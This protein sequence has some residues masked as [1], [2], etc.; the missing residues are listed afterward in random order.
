MQVLCTL[1]PQPDLHH[2]SSERSMLDMTSPSWQMGHSSLVE[3][4]RTCDWV[5]RLRGGLELVDTGR[6]E[7]LDI[8]DGVDG[9]D[10]V[11]AEIGVARRERLDMSE[12]AILEAGVTADE[13]TLGRVVE[14][15]LETE[16][17][18]LVVEV[19]ER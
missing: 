6:G 1:R 3:R 11:G 18:D 16:E 15:V 14:A 19:R 10:G 12:A 7:V 17:I 2:T 5:H 13:E 9:V 4:R 8:E